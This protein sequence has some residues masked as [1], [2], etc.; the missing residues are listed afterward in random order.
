M[1]ENSPGPSNTE[2]YIEFSNRLS[3]LHNKMDTFSVIAI[4]AGMGLFFFIIGTV[5][6][7]S[8]S[9]MP[10]QRPF[11]FTASFI[12]TISAILIFFIILGTI[13]YLRYL[14]K[15]RDLI[16]TINKDSM[17]K[18]KVAEYL[19]TQNSGSIGG[20]L[21]K[22]LKSKKGAELALD[23]LKSANKWDKRNALSVLYEMDTLNDAEIQSV[24]HI[25]LDP[26]ELLRTRTRA[27]EILK[28]TG[29]KSEKANEM[30]WY[31]LALNDWD[32][33]LKMGNAAVKPL[34]VS[35]MQTEEL[36]Y[37]TP[38][39]PKDIRVPMA[40]VLGK[41]KN[42][43]AIEPLEELLSTLKNT[44]FESKQNNPYKAVKEALETIRHGTN[45]R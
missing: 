14:R 31:Y 11:Y 34:L 12:L 18:E 24:E 2:D 8:L 19:I 40:N 30:A 23:Q 17:L 4:L 32:N 20:D 1:T 41:L 38:Q 25:L 43:D 27:A 5:F 6:L 39:I 35:I 9:N 22:D 37:G 26:E 36:N 7:E 44:P 21:I 33:L 3:F 13:L 42:T 28:K 15:Y 45:K 16:D 10:G 29:W